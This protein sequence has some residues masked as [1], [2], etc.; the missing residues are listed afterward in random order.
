MLP[1]SSAQLSAGS[2]DIMMNVITSDRGGRF[3]MHD[4][5]TALE[6][7]H[8]CRQDAHACVVLPT[9]KRPRA[10]RS[11][12][13]FMHSSSKDHPILCRFRNSLRGNR[14]L[15]FPGTRSAAVNGA[16]HNLPALEQISPLGT[17]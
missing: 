14:P 10:G 3:F 13:R 7:R 16:V 1:Y 6:S 8:E 15:P 11:R 17:A 5:P 2:N 4:H 12:N 9:L